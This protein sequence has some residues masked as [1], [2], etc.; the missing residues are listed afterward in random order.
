MEPKIGIICAGD[1]ELEPFL[2]CITEPAVSQKAMLTVYEGMLCGAR[3]AMLFSGVCKV[4]AAVATQILIDTYH[5]DAVINA[6][7]AGGMDE[8]VELFDTV[9]S[10]EVA[11]H[12]VQEDILTEFHPWMPSVFFP[13]DEGLLSAAHRAAEQVKTPVRFGRMVTGE[14]FITDDGRE[15]IN[16]KLH[17]LTVDMETAA[18]AH[19]CYVNRIPFIA[20]RTVTDTAAHSGADTFEANCERAS[21]IARDVTSVL[22]GEIKAGS[23]TNDR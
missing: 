9:I 4:N 10:N 3:V 7:T 2:S 15:E 18:I 17:P 12:D 5:V 8:T 1:S 21:R 6:G 19:V 22:I 13:A 23:P 14:A 11:Y 20:V 16:A